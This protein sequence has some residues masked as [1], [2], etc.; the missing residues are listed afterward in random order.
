MLIAAIVLLACSLSNNKQV[1]EMNEN[2]EKDQ[3]QSSEDS[4][5]LTDEKLD[6]TIKS[7]NI[8]ETK[9]SIDQMVE[10]AKAIKDLKD[11]GVI[12]QEEFEKFIEKTLQIDSIKKE[13]KSSKSKSKNYSKSDKE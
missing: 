3:E 7:Q 6:S 8:D 12:T 2:S 5:V 4:P 9:R 13:K 1:L 10:K 11:K